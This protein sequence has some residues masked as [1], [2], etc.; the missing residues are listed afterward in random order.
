[1]KFSPKVKV[2][3]GEHI[4]QIVGHDAFPEKKIKQLIAPF[5]LIRC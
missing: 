4:D 5:T 1:M 2:G 3:L